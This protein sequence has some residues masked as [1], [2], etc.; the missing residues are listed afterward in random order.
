MWRES[1]RKRLT[2]RVHF[3]LPE[4]PSVGLRDDPDGELHE[5]ILAS[6]SQHQSRKSADL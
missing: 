6:V 1:D 4:S 2:C 5:Y 3:E